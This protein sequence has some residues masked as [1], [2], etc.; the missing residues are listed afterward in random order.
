MT[1]L[2]ITPTTKVIKKES[3]PRINFPEKDPVFL[4]IVLIPSVELKERQFSEDNVKQMVEW[5]ACNA[6]GERC[7]LTSIGKFAE[8][9]H[10]DFM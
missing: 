3:T 6:L 5:T 1:E 10:N 8:E 4:A 9:I 2:F 7:K